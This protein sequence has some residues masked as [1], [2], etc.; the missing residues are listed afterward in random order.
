MRKMIIHDLRTPLTAVIVGVDML[1]RH[2]ALNEE[3]RELMTVA[4]GGGMPVM[5]RESALGGTAE[6]RAFYRAYYAP[7]RATVVIAGDGDGIVDTAAAG[8]VTGRERLLA[9]V[10]GVSL[11]VTA[12]SARPDAVERRPQRAPDEGGER[13]RRVSGGF[14]AHRQ[15]LLL[16]VRI[17]QGPIRVARQPGD[18]GSHPQGLRHRRRC[19][20]D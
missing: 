4:A 2:G 7:N 14:R 10:R 17:L 6:A 13:L 19:G 8:L 5:P 11:K 12:T 3:Q 18:R 16:D 20:D 15:H 9:W 1:Q